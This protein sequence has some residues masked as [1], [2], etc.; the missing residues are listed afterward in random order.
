MK[1]NYETNISV[2]SKCVLTNIADY[3]ATNMM[4]TKE[5]SELY[6]K[7]I[8]RCVSMLGNT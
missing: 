1:T 8:D 3:A 7:I 4:R 6:A 2:E 5:K